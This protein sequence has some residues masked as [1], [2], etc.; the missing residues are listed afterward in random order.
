MK[1]SKMPEISFD[2]LFS[3]YRQQNIYAVSESGTK[4]KLPRTS[5]YGKK[6]IPKTSLENGK[7]MI[8]IV[9]PEGQLY[10]RRK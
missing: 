8:Q 4:N 10:A 6:C 1:S 3:S 5:L 7:Y 2:K 9:T